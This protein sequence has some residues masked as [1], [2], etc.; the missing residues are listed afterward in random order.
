MSF[1]QERAPEYARLL[2]AMIEDWRQQW[3]E[4]DFPF[5]YAQISSFRGTAQDAWGV[6]RDG[7]RRALSLRNTGMAVTMDVGNPDSV[8]PTD[9]QTV[10]HRLASLAEVIAYEKKGSPSGTL[11]SCGQTWE[12]T[13]LRVRFSATNLVCKSTCS[14]FEVA[15]A[16]HNFVPAQASVREDNVWVSA[17]PVAQPVYVRYAWANY[18]AV[19]LFDGEGLPASTFTNEDELADRFL[20]PGSF[21]QTGN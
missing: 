17:P 14:G 5:L 1:W 13:G 8:H 18:P 20:I 3:S 9:K 10:G 16:D 7:Q 2:P 11:C 21:G 15:G 6:V 12:G 19:S 4:G